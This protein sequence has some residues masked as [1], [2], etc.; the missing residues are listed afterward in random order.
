MKVYAHYKEVGNIAYRWRTLLQFGSSWHIIGSVVMKN[1]GS[2]YPVKE[3]HLPE[4]YAIDGT[5]EWY[6]FKGDI[7]MTCIS[8]LFTEYHKTD[9]LNGVIQIFNLFNVKEANLNKALT[10]YGDCCPSTIEQDLSDIV[11]PAYL[12]WG[13][14]GT[15]SR[16]REQATRF[17]DVVKAQKHYLDNNFNAN[18][19]FH[20]LY[21]MRYGKTKGNVKKVRAA[22]TSA[23]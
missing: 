10:L 2:A 8:E 9:H 1:P 12:G 19:F 18:P 15:D 14:L 11:L 16:F 17:F 5:S 20:P 21:L 22:F 23:L 3:V 7:T 6:E 4:L 13:K